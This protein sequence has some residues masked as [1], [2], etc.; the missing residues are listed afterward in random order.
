[1]L[2]LMDQT[3][4]EDELFLSMM[5]GDDCEVNLSEMS[6][7]QR[8]NLDEKNWATALIAYVSVSEE[9]R[10]SKLTDEY[11][12]KVTDQFS[13]GEYRDK[14]LANMQDIWRDFLS[15]KNL[16]V[17]VKLAIIGDTV[18]SAGGAGNLKHVE[19]LGNLTEEVRRTLNHDKVA[20][21]TKEELKNLLSLQEARMAREKWSQDDRS[22]FYGLSLDILQAAPSL[23]TTFG[24]VLEN[25][26]PKEM[27]LFMSETFP[28]YQAQL[29][30][31]QTETND[32]GDAA[33]NPQIW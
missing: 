3:D 20:Q 2:A 32:N 25:L 9:H 30:T 13:E 12:K 10:S 28:L 7:S 31:V 24:P 5:L 6:E 17:P 16:A 27:K 33:Y 15:N 21:K 4:E 14:A 18:R 11:K 1:M 26:S 29:V 19:S 8:E 23:Y 22:L